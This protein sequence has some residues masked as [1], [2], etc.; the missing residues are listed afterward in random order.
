[1]CTKLTNSP[2]PTKPM[3]LQKQPRGCAGQISRKRAISVQQTKCFLL[4]S[5]HASRLFPALVCR[6]KKKMAYC[7]TCTAART[8]KQSPAALHLSTPI[9]RKTVYILTAA[10]K[11]KKT[12]QTLT[13]PRREPHQDKLLPMPS[14]GSCALGTAAE[15]AGGAT[16]AAPAP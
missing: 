15:R 3:N 7:C 14:P 1:M 5:L 6:K 16:N 2:I 4:L 10:N 13:G 8:T 9:Y 12:K 11:R